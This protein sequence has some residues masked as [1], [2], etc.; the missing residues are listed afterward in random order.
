MRKSSRVEPHSSQEPAERDGPA[1]E[2]RPLVALS[3]MLWGIDWSSHLPMHLEDGVI[4]R[5]SS[6]D[7]SAPFVRQHYAR[8]FKEDGSSPFSTTRIDPA[9]ERYYRLAGDFFTW[10]LEG[11]AIGL[12]VGTPVDWSTYYIRSAAIL[13]EH[14]GKGLIPSFLPRL[15][16]ILAAAGLE[17][18]EADTSPSN[19]AVMRI[20]T[21][22][23]FNVTGTMLTD[24]WGAHV[25]LTRYLNAEREEVFLQQFCS[26][27]RYQQG[28][29]HAGGNSNSE[30][31]RP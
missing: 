5:Q 21:R 9:K 23:N 24:R 12:L 16:E 14:F 31:S 4:V 19:L 10:E 20:L 11:E 1:S 3:S 2:R 29:G 27:I 28:R 6:Y 26:G 25:H 22:M 30:R 17:R 8:I 15:F 18:V 13:P 7:E